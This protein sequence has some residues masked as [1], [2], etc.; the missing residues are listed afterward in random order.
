MGFLMMKARVL[1]P[2]LARLEMRRRIVDIFG[3][4]VC[5]RLE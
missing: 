4:M 3:G 5:G 2:S 1:R